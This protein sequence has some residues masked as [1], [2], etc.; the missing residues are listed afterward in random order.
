ML[1]RKWQTIAYKQ[2]RGT[3]VY[4]KCTQDVNVHKWK[5]FFFCHIVPH[6]DNGLF[7]KKKE[8]RQI[9]TLWVGSVSSEL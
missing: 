6:V 5:A 3:A 9:Q 7:K 4:K 1:V 8:K 2:R